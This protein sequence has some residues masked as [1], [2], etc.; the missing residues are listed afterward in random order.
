MKKRWTPN[1]PIS[2]DGRRQFTIWQKRLILRE[3]MEEGVSVSLLARKYQVHPVTIYNWKRMIDLAGDPVD[4]HA[5]IDDLLAELERLKKENHRLKFAVGDLTLEKLCQLEVIDSLKKKSRDTL[6]ET[7][8]ESSS[9]MA[10]PS[11]GSAESL[12]EADSGSTNS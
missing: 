7:Q 6:L 1:K 12:G 3:H 5:A 8:R 10:E 2:K 4:P 11:N 9:E